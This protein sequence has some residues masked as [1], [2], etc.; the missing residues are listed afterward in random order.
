MENVPNIDS[1]WCENKIDQFQICQSKLQSY[2]RL[3]ISDIEIIMNKLPVPVGYAVV[4]SHRIR[5]P[6][7]HF[8]LN[9]SYTDLITCWSVLL[10][11]RSIVIRLL[12]SY[13]KRSFP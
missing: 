6:F 9:C 2:Y 13:K 1:K 12:N 5:R 3:Q 10:V 7:A 4:L 8:H 11:N